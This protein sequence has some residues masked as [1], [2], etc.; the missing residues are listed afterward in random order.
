[1]RLLLILW[2]IIRRLVK[3]AL[4]IG[5]PAVGLVGALYLYSQM[6]N[7]NEKAQ[8]FAAEIRR[9]TGRTLFIEGSSDFAFFP[10]PTLTLKRV[11]LD[12]IPGA[13]NGSFL[14]APAAIITLSPISFLTGENKA[15]DI[16][17]VA[18]T[19]ALEILDDGR[20]TWDFTQAIRTDQAVIE[21]A[22]AAPS[23]APEPGSTLPVETFT[24]KEAT[25][26]A[27]N[28]KTSYDSAILKASG[29]LR[30]ETAL[31]P[32][33]FE[34][35]LIRNNTPLA[36]QFTLG[37]WQEGN[38]PYSLN[39]K[40]SRSDLTLKGLVSRSANGWQVDGALTGIVHPS[41]L[42]FGDRLENPEVVQ[43]SGNLSGSDT[44]LSMRNT[45][46]KSA[47]LEGAGDIVLKMD[48]AVPYLDANL[49][50]D[51]IALAAD[52]LLP[53]G[54]LTFDPTPESAATDASYRAGDIGLGRY[55]ELNLLSDIGMQ[56][57]IGAKNVQFRN[58]SIQNARLNVISAPGK[59][60]LEVRN[61]SA[62]LPG[63]TSV[64]MNGRLEEKPGADSNAPHTLNFAG[65]V[66]IAGA[67]FKNFLTWMKVDLPPVPEGKLG[68][69]A[70]NA[71]AVVSEGAFALPAIVARVD[72]TL[73]TGGSAQVGAAGGPSQ[74]SLSMENLNLDNYLPDLD[75][76]IAEKGG[77]ATE[78]QYQQLNATM[79]RF[80]FLRT[81]QTTFGAFNLQLMT[82]N[83]TY[84]GENIPE[85][86]ATIR[87]GTAQMEFDNLF[88]RAADFA[89]T[90]RVAFDASKL[91]PE[92][93]AALDFESLD[94]ESIPEIRVLFAGVDNEKP[95]DAAEGAPDLSDRWSKEL[96]DL[97]DFTLFDGKFRLFFKELTHRAVAFKNLSISG[98]LQQN[99]IN[100]DSIRGELFDGGKMEGK[101]A[102]NVAQSPSISLSFSLSN[103]GVGQAMQELFGV[104]A[105]KEGRFSASGSVTTLGQDVR[106]L[107]VQAAGTINVVA[108][109]LAF[110]GFDLTG[111][112]EQLARMIGI[113]QLRE[114]SDSYLAHGTTRYD[115]ATGALT[116]GGGA[117]GLNNLSITSSRLPPMTLQGNVNLGA[118]SYDV[119]AETRLPLR[120]DGS[121]QWSGQATNDDVVIPLRITGPIDN[122]T[123]EFNKTNIEKY[124]EKRFY[125]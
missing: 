76:L 18:P 104:T 49:V 81:V 20:R 44:L 106:S 51:R 39:V 28:R 6:I 59:N 117:I 2:G 67:S 43:V 48:G 72:D 42:P 115:Y 62:L 114:I 13:V 58:E 99:Y 71:N 19:I 79:R 97:R 36:T 15:E 60:V 102:I 57:D 14:S 27:Y 40:P 94:T 73:I 87:F 66:K 38:I 112:T 17:L 120:S 107:L 31:G 10:R 88:V 103:G 45:V 69:F 23:S 68:A 80:D 35:T 37:K 7:W 101:A 75:T 9:I 41:L 113:K 91:R 105:V 100:V 70:L 90:G 89:V 77:E 34:G 64:E 52:Q 24:L 46:L 86:G 108:R 85:A 65:Q 22:A 56:V 84:R 83:L 109:G 93:D 121:I 33:A 110:E 11:R 26:R 122:P 5:I 96:L 53:Q 98:R 3:L 124:W 54:F 74:L 125:R 30:A 118:W 16:T 21:S 47:S 25:F 92:I 95:A 123:A 50:L 111:L 63:N 4:W 1:M 32:Y 82:K 61:V 116:L 78:Q 55:Y 119:L 8:E 12:N 29:V